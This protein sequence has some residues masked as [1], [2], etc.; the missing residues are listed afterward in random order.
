MDRVGIWDNVENSGAGDNH[1][2]LQCVAERNPELGIPLQ[3]SPNSKSTVFREIIKRLEH[4][5]CV[6]GYS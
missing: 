4:K 3:G 1:C 6:E 5:V 2:S